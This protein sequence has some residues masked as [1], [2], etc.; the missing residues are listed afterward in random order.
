MLLIMAEVTKE[1]MKLAIKVFN[2]GQFKYKTSCTQ[3]FNVPPQTLM[4]CLNGVTYEES[5]TNGWKL[6][7]IK[8]ITPSKWILDIYI[9]VAYLSRYLM[10]ATLLNYSYQHGWSPLRKPLLVSYR[11]TSLSNAIL[12]LNPNV[13]AHMITS[14]PNIKTHN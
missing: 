12:S 9:T 4:K 14:V 10:S 5:I 13:L 1:S 11:L 7:H 6:S 8:E 3:A 2:H